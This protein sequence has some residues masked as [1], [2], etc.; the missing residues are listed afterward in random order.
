M[1]AKSFRE[2]SPQ[3]EWILV[4]VHSS[5]FILNV[6]NICASKIFILL[7][8]HSG[9]DP[10]SSLNGSLLSQGRSLDS[11]WSLPRT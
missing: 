7:N 2:F 4:F 5:K 9:L 3:E 11:R 6:I 8:C 10:E 1:E